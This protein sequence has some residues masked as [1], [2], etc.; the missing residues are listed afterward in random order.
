MQLEN[1]LAPI[2][3]TGFPR[4]IEHY[5]VVF[6][7]EPSMEKPWAWR[8]EGHHISFSV[9]VVPDGIS[10][11]PSFLGADPADVRFG[12]LA[13]VH[14]L[15][16]EED[17]GR[18]L[19]NALNEVQRKEVMIAGDP[20]YNEV[21]AKFGI[22]NPYNV[23]WDLISSNILKPR[24]QWD[25]WKTLLKPDGIAA[26]GFNDEQRALLRRIVDE[27]VTTYRPEIAQTHLN[28][29]DLDALS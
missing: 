17:A 3:D 14:L 28:S 21:V 4:G 7:G 11:T 25:V 18:S 2:A 19:I 16:I 10:V 1:V 26:R 24:D 20:E 27:V 29:I 23:P 9:T 5:S 15:R 6:F 22:T 8:F 12:Q 13:G